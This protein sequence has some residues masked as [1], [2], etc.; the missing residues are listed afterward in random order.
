MKKKLLKITIL[1]I[2]LL[3]LTVTAASA[4]LGDISKAFPNAN[5]NT[6]K[7]IVSLPALLIIPFTLLC[8][9]LSN[10][11]GKRKLLFTG[12]ILFLV[13]GVGPSF[14]NNLT[15]ILLLRAI[16]GIGMGFI[17]PLATGL[18][19]DFYEGEERA[20]MMGLQS[21]VVN[22]GAIVTSLIAGFLSAI[23][24]HYVFL[25]YLLGVAVLCLTFF[26][27]PEPEKLQYAITEK[28][29]LSWS[30]YGIALLALLY[31]LLIFSFFTNIAMVITEEHL[32]NAAS[33]G[34]VI[35]IMTVG[36][37]LAGILFGKV[38]Q[39]LKRFTIPLSAVLTGLGFLM[40]SYSY[41]FHLILIAS[42]LIGIGFGTTMPAVMMK[43]AENAPKFAITLAMA[44]VTSAMSLGQFVSPFALTFVETLLDS[45][46]GRFTFIL[47]GV[48]I[49]IGGTVLLLL[50]LR[51]K[52]MHENVGEIR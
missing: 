15:F 34:I 35:T 17:M 50:N 26:K 45:G 6:I 23:N 48:G 40:L 12:L 19:A 10:V 20:A 4:A 3:L 18:I 11:M 52:T 16:L 39:T 28:Q 42:L 5:S 44:V 1:S 31:S 22:I 24:W 27:L 13:G 49:L 7:L 2:S 8:G 46:T 36:G 51:A 38:S 37:L 41:S 32:G 30:I 9:K 29:S 21:A 47:S 14:S 33:A 43:I 25:V